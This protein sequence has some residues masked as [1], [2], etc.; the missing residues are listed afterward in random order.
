MKFQ[1]S[2]HVFCITEITHMA[3]HVDRVTIL[4]MSLP[5]YRWCQFF[6]FS[7]QMSS[8]TAGGL[9]SSDTRVLLSPR[10]KPII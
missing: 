7:V 10:F 5:S 6:N 9:L 8:L 1:D 2:I 3:D 4:W